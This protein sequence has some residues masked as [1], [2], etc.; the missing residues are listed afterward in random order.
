MKIQTI[1]AGVRTS[2]AR[3]R[4][5]LQDFHP[6]VHTLVLGTVLARAASSMSIPFLAIYLSRYSQ[7][8]IVGTSLIVGASSLAGTVGG[9]IG[10]TISDRIG[11]KTVMLAALFCWSL[12]F[13]GFG[14]A[15][16]PLAFVLLN[17]LNGLCR[18]F[19]EPVSQALMADLTPKEKR[20]KVFSMR[21]FAINVGVAV[22]PLAGAYFSTR[23]ASMAFML[24]GLIYFIY[25]VALQ[26]LLTRF[27]IRRIEGEERKD[28]TFKRA[29]GV[30][31]RDRKFRY[32]LAGAT[33]GSISYS[34]MN[35]TLSQYLDHSFSNGVG[36][37]GTL[38]S[39]NAV[40]VILFQLPLTSLGGK[41][42]PITSIVWGNLLFSLGNI[43]Y[44]FSHHEAA[45][46]ASMFIFTLGEI[47]C[48]PAGNLLIDGIAPEGM[49]GTYF[50]AQT[51]QNVGQF[52]GPLLGGV[53]LTQANGTVLFSVM[54]VMTCIGTWFY[55]RGDRLKPHPH[56]L[57]A[58]D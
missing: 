27:G 28:A 36:L 47:L 58:A 21:Y 14:L 30:I 7:A 25:A 50:G 17:L 54:A 32:I 34:Q 26:I 13:V 10:G 39:L 23:N 9:F 46:L 37:F 38:I 43:G 5:Y 20:F 51:L 22:G 42:S 6:V 11:R 57:R 52:L 12:V 48:F 40:T 8:G 18:S 53:L 16:S 3:A 19:Y 41:R 56:P 45:F 2:P 49:R 1:A 15:R 4:A 44:A 55:L 29:L 35:V 31:R 33:V 24:T